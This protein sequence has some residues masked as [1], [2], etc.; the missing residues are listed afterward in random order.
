MYSL[1]PFVSL[2]ALGLA[3]V[4]AAPP[5]VT[6]PA[7]KIIGTTCPSGPSAFLSIPFAE[8]PIGDLRWTIPQEY[9]QTFP[10]GGLNATTKGAL[11]IQFGGVEF[12]EQ[13]GDSENW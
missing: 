7:G 1:R 8:P 3:I 2:V 6:I 5:S 4:E 12:T 13:G 11:C 10:T 9:N